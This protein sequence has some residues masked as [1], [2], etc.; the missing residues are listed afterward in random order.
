MS[1]ISFSFYSFILVL[2][3]LQGLL[4][5]S[6]FIFNKKFQKKS[7][8]SLAAILVVL[9]IT[10]VGNFLQ[11]IGLN[12]IY[13][14]LNY[15]PIYYSIVIGLGY[16][17][18]TVFLLDSN[19]QLNQKNYLFIAPLGVIFILNTLIYI[20]YLVNPSFIELNAEL[21]TRYNLT[22]ELLGVLYLLVVMILVLKMIKDYHNQLLENYSEIEGSNIYWLRNVTYLVLI[23]WITWL[24]TEIYYATYRER[25]WIFD[26]AWLLICVLVYWMGYFVISRRDIFEI[27]VFKNEEEIIEK[28]SILSDKTEEHYRNLIKLMEEEKLYREPK[29]NMDMLAEKSNLSNGYLSQIINQKEG[30]NFYD[31]I[32]SYRVAEVKSHL[33]DPQYDHYSILGIGLEAG[34]KSKSTFNAVFKKMTGQTPSGFKKSVK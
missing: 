21:V 5:A 4:L 32:N 19:Y 26:Y 24:I 1:E 11:E 18:F 23:I 10:G 31:F 16:Y 25:F 13:P 27:P 6:I 20:T 2:V 12:D 33:T 15:L 14:N 8:L 30:K 29:L 3:I 28:K 17:Y 34:F 9:S 7:N 22:R